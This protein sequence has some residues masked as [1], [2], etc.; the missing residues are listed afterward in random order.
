MGAPGPDHPNQPWAIGIKRSSAPTVSR[1]FH[2]AA[3][4]LDATARHVMHV[5]HG[6]H[7][8]Q[9]G[10][11]LAHEALAMTLVELQSDLQHVLVEL[12]VAS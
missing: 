9:D 1:G 10:F 3:A 8:M 5:M 12:V 2:T 7:V 6:L 4:D 11:S